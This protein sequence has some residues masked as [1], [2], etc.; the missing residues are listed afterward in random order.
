MISQ[1]VSGMKICIIILIYIRFW[2]AFILLKTPVDIFYK[3]LQFFKELQMVSQHLKFAE[4]IR[5]MKVHLLRFLVIRQ[6]K[7]VHLQRSYS[8]TDF[9]KDMSGYFGERYVLLSLL[10]VFQTDGNCL[11]SLLKS[12]EELGWNLCLLIPDMKNYP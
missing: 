2:K 11:K 3:M 4:W 5:Y 1:A 7:L 6:E 10:F 9:L 12:A 8:F